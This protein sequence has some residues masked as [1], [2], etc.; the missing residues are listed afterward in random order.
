MIK[1]GLVGAFDRNNFGDVLMPVVIEKKLKNT[2]GNH[3]VISYFGLAEKDM[4]SIGGYKTT[5]LCNAYNTQDVIIVVGG[6]VLSYE[7]SYGNMFMHLQSNWLKICFYRFLRKFF[8]SR[9]EQLCKKKLNGYEL[10]PWIL[11]KKK[12]KCK[13]LI[14]NTVGGPLS[15]AVSKEI[16]QVD[17]IS[18]RNRHDY[19]IIK[20]LNNNAILCPDSMIIAPDVLGY[21]ELENKSGRD[22][23]GLV[24]SDYFVVQIGKRMISHKEYRILSNNI[25]RIINDYKI[26]CFLLP[27]GY[28]PAHEDQIELKKIKAFCTRKVTLIRKTN[29]YELMLI[30]S[31]A[32]MFFG[33]SLHGNIIA[34]AC[35]VPH[36]VIGTKNNKLNNYMTTWYPGISKTVSPVRLIDVF[37]NVMHNYD[38][39]KKETEKTAK[40]DKALVLENMNNIE[41][42]IKDTFSF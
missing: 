12:L 15:D 40:E 28:A 13:L 5:S 26:K 6:D 35:N 19:N 32:R 30:I 36:F 2:F 24:K 23:V 31:K 25:D 8:C 41:S 29:I 16:S 33:S 11:D 3:I 21:D 20:K 22:I 39:I 1:V 10:Y 18:V 34:Q 14:Y 38:E 7:N 17:Y 27:I 42:K 37:E 9:F 4:T